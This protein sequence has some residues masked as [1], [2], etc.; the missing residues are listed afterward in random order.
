MESFGSSKKL[1]SVNSL[2]E[3]GK[4]EALNSQ[5]PETVKEAFGFGGSIK[6]NKDDPEIIVVVTFKEKVSLTGLLIESYNDG[7]QPNTVQLFPN[8][9]SISFSDIGVVPST[10]TFKNYTSGKQYPLKIAKYRNIDTLVLYIANESGSIVE[11][12]NIT[13]YGTSA[14]NT[15]MSQMKNTNP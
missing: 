14:E 1:V 8:K 12:N 13:L 6:S 4:C 11:V 9:T 3:F 10:E 15:D 7:N 2:I 5:S